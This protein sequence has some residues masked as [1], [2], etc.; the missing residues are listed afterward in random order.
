MR[1]AI[2]RQAIVRQAI[3]RQAIVRQAIVRQAILVLVLVLVRM[4]LEDTDPHRPLLSPLASL[5][6]LTECPI[7]LVHKDVEPARERVLISICDSVTFNTLPSIRSYIESA[8]ERAW[9]HERD[10]INTLTA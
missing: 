7:L 8:R 3:V 6:P 9:V 1:Q 4:V 2:V 10:S 5:F